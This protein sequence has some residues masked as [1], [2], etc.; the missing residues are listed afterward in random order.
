M[1]A[2]RHLQE[3]WHRQ[4]HFLRKSSAWMKLWAFPEI[5]WSKDTRSL[6]PFTS[7]FA[8]TKTVQG[9]N[10]C[11]LLWPQ[12]KIASYLWPESALAASKIISF[13][14]AMIPTN[15]DLKKRSLVRVWRPRFCHR[16]KRNRYRSIWWS[17]RSQAIE[18]L[19]PVRLNLPPLKAPNYFR[20]A[21]DTIQWGQECSSKEY[22]RQSPTRPVT[23]R[24][25]CPNR[26]TFGFL[27]L[28]PL[29]Q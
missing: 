13:V 17:C 7:R 12:R 25:W 3:K 20:F 14:T 6:K 19:R 28:L 22:R 5:F 24:Q 21:S 8:K 15:T 2:T 11:P 26:S 16:R 1:R 18:Y 29:R 27:R 10:T 4:D 9:T 23:Y